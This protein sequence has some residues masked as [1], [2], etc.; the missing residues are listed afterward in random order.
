MTDFGISTRF[1]QDHTAETGT[2]RYMAPEVSAHQKYDYRCDV[3]SYGMLVWETLHREMPFKDASPLQAAF[4]VAMQNARPPLRLHHLR[5]GEGRLGMETVPG[6]STAC[7]MAD[8]CS[9]ALA[10]GGLAG[11][12]TAARSAALRAAS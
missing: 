12:G 5:G 7:S 2:Y 8:H 10:G 6:L 3:Y 4:A 1:K 9:C 11:G